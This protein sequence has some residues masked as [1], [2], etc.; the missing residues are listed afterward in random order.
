VGGLIQGKVAGAK[1]VQGSGQPGD[2]ISILLRSARSILL[3]QDPLVVVDGVITD[4][5]GL[6]IDP[7]DVESVEILKGAGA[8]AIYGSRGQ[9]GVVEITTKRG[10]VGDTAPRGPVLVVD[11][12]MTHLT[13]ADV[14]PA[15]IA[16][17]R[18]FDGPAGAVLYGP[19]GEAGVIQIITHG[20]PPEA[21]LP[22]FCRLPG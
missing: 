14:N 20:A 6:D 1:V 7:S 22:P 13:L 19:R 18:K 3:D 17:I 11:G 21:E 10:P 9:A 4:R 16:T 5:R 12:V 15:D 2:Q 8:S